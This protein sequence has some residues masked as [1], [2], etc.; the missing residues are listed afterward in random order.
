[1]QILLATSNHH[2][3]LEV[4]EILEPLGVEVLGLDSLEIEVEEPIEDAETFAGNAKLKALGYATA[5]GLRCM[6]D[7]SGLSVDALEGKPGVYS[8]RFAGIGTTRDERDEANNALL[9]QKLK[10]IPEDKRIARF[11][12]AICIADPDGT[13]VG[14]STG[15]FD[16]VITIEPRGTNGF[17]YDP[18]LYIP[19]AQK[20]TAEM[21]SQEKMPAL[22]E[23]KRSEI[24]LLASNRKQRDFCWAIH[25]KRK[26]K[27]QRQQSHTIDNHQP[28]TYQRCTYEQSLDSH[29]CF[30]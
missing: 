6:A 21:T 19:D 24:L 2:K 28:H 1:M 11:V 10:G 14:E 13:I 29:P 16:G 12:C 3:L 15:T 17:G 8:A 25:P 7:D 27:P 20:T 26:T 18:L 9:L 4:C 30:S 22:I 23:A 5:T